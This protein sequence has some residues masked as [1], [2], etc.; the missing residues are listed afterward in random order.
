MF[1]ATGWQKY[2]SLW[3]CPR[4][5]SGAIDALGFLDP[6][7]ERRYVRYKIDGKSSVEY[8]PHGATT[9][10]QKRADAADATGGER[11][12]WGE[13]NRATDQAGRSNSGY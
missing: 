9:D 10:D 3:G 12:G 4:D 11:A 2:A 1:L 8:H 13:Q 7:T 5:Q 6:D